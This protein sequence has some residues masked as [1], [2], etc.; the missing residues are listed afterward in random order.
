MHKKL[1][2]IAGGGAGEPVGFGHRGACQAILRLERRSVVLGIDARLFPMRARGG[3]C[4]R[5]SGSVHR[6]RARTGSGL[7]AEC[8]P[9]DSLEGC[10]WRS[11]ASRLRPKRLDRKSTRLNSSH[12]R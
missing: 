3:A 11:V 7:D 5:V 8:V 2:I 12:A 9:R 1:G 10:R 4:F 6:R